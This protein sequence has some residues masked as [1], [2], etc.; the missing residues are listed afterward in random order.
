[1][2]KWKSHSDWYR[3]LCDD[4]REHLREMLGSWCNRV[5]AM[6][7]LVPPAGP[8]KG[9]CYQGLSLRALFDDGEEFYVTWNPNHPR[10]CREGDIAAWA[11]RRL[12]SQR[13]LSV[14]L[15]DTA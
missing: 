2:M 9:R 10:H 14:S 3:P 8:A 6:A 13:L 15:Q 11:A 5:E 7:H 12:A 1:M 4:V